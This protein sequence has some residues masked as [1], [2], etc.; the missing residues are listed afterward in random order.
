M[1][2]YTYTCD[3]LDRV[4][5][6]C[7]NGVQRASYTYAPNGNISMITDHGTGINYLYYYTSDGEL[8]SVRACD[9]NG[10]IQYITRYE[11]DTESRLASKLI[12]FIS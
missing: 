2:L 6:E 4:V 12:Y 3:I 9:S 5:G 10:D 1:V 7:Y 11:Y 8:A